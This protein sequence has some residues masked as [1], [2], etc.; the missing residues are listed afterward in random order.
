MRFDIETLGL[1]DSLLT[2]DRETILCGYDTDDA[3]PT[4]WLGR[5]YEQFAVEI[6][7]WLGGPLDRWVLS[8]F[9]GFEHFS[10]K[11]VPEIGSGGTIAI[12]WSSR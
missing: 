12:H 5:E 4:I 9:P 1:C 6:V 10:L 11:I 7:L 2:G 3:P 8:S